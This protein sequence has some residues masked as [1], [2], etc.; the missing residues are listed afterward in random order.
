MKETKEFLRE[1][2]EQFVAIEAG[3][4]HSEAFTGESYAYLWFALGAVAGGL[5]NAV[6]QDLWN[7]IKT[8]FKKIFSKICVR[9]NVFEVAFSFKEIDVI[10]HY[11]SR[12]PSS[13]PKMLDEADDIL[14]ELK[15]VFFDN[16]ENLEGLRTIE[17]RRQ[18]DGSYGCVYYS[19]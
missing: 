16:K 12:K 8:G 15:K 4:V 10:F 19:Y 18:Q 13:I 3:G 6:G 2:T 9:R 7:V 14:D 1:N 17:L 5:L 11:E